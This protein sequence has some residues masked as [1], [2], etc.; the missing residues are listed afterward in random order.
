MSGMF[1]PTCLKKK[2]TDVKPSVA[3][4]HCGCLFSDLLADSEFVLLADSE[5]VFFLMFCK[6]GENG[7][8]CVHTN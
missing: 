7:D 1:Y 8:H 2:T 4:C 3:V 5:S 6:L